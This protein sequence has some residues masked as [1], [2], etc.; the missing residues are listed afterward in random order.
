[1]NE[2]Q[3]ILEADIAITATA[4]RVPVFMSHSEA[5][6]IETEKAVDVDMF[7]KLLT[8]FDGVTVMDDPAQRVSNSSICSWQRRCLCWSN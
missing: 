6:N 5:V 2:T 1:M 3:K 4:V 8:D 7:R